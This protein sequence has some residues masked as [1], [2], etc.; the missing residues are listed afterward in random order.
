MK[1][2]FRSNNPNP[3]YLKSMKSGFRS[4]NPNP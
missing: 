1:S 4:N 3:Q 2:R